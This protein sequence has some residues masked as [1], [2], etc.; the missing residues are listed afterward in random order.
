M[1]K[2]PHSRS[3][4]RPLVVYLVIILQVAGVL[5]VLLLTVPDVRRFYE[6]DRS[7]GGVD[8]G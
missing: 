1:I 8:R 7:D 4:S 6:T 3:R 5:A 2:E